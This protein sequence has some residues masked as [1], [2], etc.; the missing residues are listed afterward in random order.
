MAIKTV[1]VSLRSYDFDFRASATTL[2]FPK[3]FPS[4]QIIFLTLCS[5]PIL[6][7]HISPMPFNFRILVGFSSVRPF[8]SSAVRSSFLPVSPF[9]F[10]VVSWALPFLSFYE[11][12]VCM[13]P[14]RTHHNIALFYHPRVQIEFASKSNTTRLRCVTNS[15]DGVIKIKVQHLHSG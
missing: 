8:S 14:F 6:S 13:T 7:A 15:S 12:T 2:D 9:P 5:S 10:F 3:P 11:L 4:F 1:I